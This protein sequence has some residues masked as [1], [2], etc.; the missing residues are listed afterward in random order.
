MKYTMMYLA[1]V[2]ILQGCVV[3]I[4]TGEGR[5]LTE[6]ERVELETQIEVLEKELQAIEI[7]GEAA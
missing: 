4:N 7:A 5:K 2:L 1:A 6:E 3:A